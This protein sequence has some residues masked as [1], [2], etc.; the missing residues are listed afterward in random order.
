DA[1]TPATRLGVLNDAALGH[2]AVPL[3]PQLLRN[4]AGPGNTLGIQ[5][6]LIRGERIFLTK[7]NPSTGVLGT[8]PKLVLQY[9]V[10]S[11]SPPVAEAGG[12]YTVSEGQ[13]LAL[14]AGGSS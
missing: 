13:G 9:E 4:A 7:V 8:T 3:D 12:P 5:V 6:N 11:T 2:F 1:T 10:P 14:D